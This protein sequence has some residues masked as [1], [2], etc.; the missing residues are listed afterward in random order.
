MKSS[1]V[2]G[3]LI[4]SITSYAQSIDELM[5]AETPKETE[6]IIATF[7]GNKVLN[8]HSIEGVGKGVLQVNFQHRF[9]TLE[10][11]FYDFFGL[12]QASI[13]FGF[14]YG[15]N[16]RLSI[17]VGRSSIQKAYDGYIKYRLLRQSIG[18]ASMPVSVT[19]YGST[20]INTLRTNLWLPIGAEDN[21][22]YRLYYV[23]QV[24]IA[25]KFS[26][27]FSLQLMPT[28][29]HRNFTEL[30]SEKNMLFSL[31]VAARYKLT[32]RFGIV[33]EGY[34]TSPSFIGA[35]YTPFVLGAG[36]EI[37]TGGHVYHLLFTNARG[38]IEHQIIG[39]TVDKIENGIYAIRFG[40]NLSRVFTLVN[41]NR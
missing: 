29:I 13:R 21:F 35:N 6:Y 4:L 41:P 25:R 5:E 15:I 10:N 27:K 26:E 28:V 38:L 16:N 40:F 14:D 1:I 24:L 18:T 19:L 39:N 23:G 31:G 34:Y 36:L 12:D 20:A 3:L 2:F 33:T 9:G 22:A 32:K 37:E 7:K 30:A 17:G 8:T 11:N